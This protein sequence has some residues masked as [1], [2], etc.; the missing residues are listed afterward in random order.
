VGSKLSDRQRR[1]LPRAL[2]AGAGRLH[3]LLQHALSLGPAD[4][5]LRADPRVV[6]FCDAYSAACEFFCSG[7]PQDCLTALRVLSQRHPD[8]LPADALPLQNATTAATRLSPSNA[9]SI[10]GYSTTPPLSSI[11]PAHSGTFG[12]SPTPEVP[13]IAATSGHDAALLALSGS[14]MLE[15]QPASATLPYTTLSLSVA[16]SAR[17]LAEECQRELADA[18][19]VYEGVMRALEK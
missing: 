5:A 18:E 4:T 7:R 8:L 10:N 3:Q 1:H 12:R 16:V 6:A 11:A 13:E 14:A 19:G 15:H 17:Y 9:R 2:R